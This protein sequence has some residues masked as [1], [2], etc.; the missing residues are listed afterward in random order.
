MQRQLYEA[1]TSWSES[2]QDDKKK[3]NDPNNACVEGGSEDHCLQPIEPTGREEGCLH[4]LEWKTE[5]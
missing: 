1:T 4:I 3:C 2:D 5:N